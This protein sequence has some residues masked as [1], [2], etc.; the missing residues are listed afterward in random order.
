MYWGILLEYE[1]I[2]PESTWHK[3]LG[4][5]W[6]DLRIKGSSAELICQETDEELI[7]VK[8]GKRRICKMQELYRPL[9]LQLFTPLTDYVPVM[10]M[11]Y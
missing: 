7:L 1:V 9:L 5:S 4:A 11:L 6:E 10:I 2:I 3:D 8:K